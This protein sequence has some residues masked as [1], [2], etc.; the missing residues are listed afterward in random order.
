MIKK[1]KKEIDEI[2]SSSMA[3]IAFLLLLFF[4]V[5]TTIDPG[6]GLTMV[7]PPYEADPLIKDADDIVKILVRSSGQV[8]FDGE[9]MGIEQIES[10]AKNKVQEFQISRS[11]SDIDG[12]GKQPIFVVITDDKAKFQIFLDVLDQL[13]LAECRKISVVE[14]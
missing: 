9:M 14:S 6:E 8:L 13:K 4:L 2:N 5:T 1:Q 10:S 12:K 11:G 7:L 3:D